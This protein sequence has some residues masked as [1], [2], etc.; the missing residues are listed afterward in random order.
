MGATIRVT[1]R[2]AGLE[3]SAWHARMI[4][5]LRA[6][7]GVEVAET[8]EPRPLLP[9]DVFLD[10][11]D[12]ALIPGGEPHPRFG[13]WRFVYGPEA[14]LVQPCA[15]EHAAGERGALA[16]LV[17][18]SAEGVASELQVG[19]IETVA[20]SLNSTRARMFDAVAEWPARALRRLLEESFASVCGSIV[21]ITRNAQPVESI[22][23]V[24]G[25]AR[26]IAQ[27]AIE[28]HWTIGL[29]RKPVSHVLQSF[30]ANAI[31][32]LAPPE[33]A[34]LADPLGAF[35]RDGRLTILAE[36]YDFT[37][38]QGRIV[39]IDV[40]VAPGHEPSSAASGG[41]E[42]VASARVA[43]R[44]PVVVTPR[45][46]LRLP[47]DASYPH[48]ISHG[49]HIYCLPEASASGRV[50]LYRADPFPDRWTPDRVLLQG[51]AGVD[52][53]LHRHAG[54]WWMFVGNLADQDETR[55]SVFHAS[56]LFGPWEPH[57]LNP[58]K[59]DLR[60][61]RSAGPL[62]EHEGAL[63]RPAQDG[64]VA[65]GGAVAVNRITALSPTQFSEET[66]AVLRP[67]ADGPYPHGLHTLTGVGSYTLVDGKRHVPSIK[68]L[69]WG[70]RQVVRRR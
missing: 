10:P 52:A 47:V 26:R 7:P 50:Q 44:E 30:D 41:K 16:R 17:C 31:E 40:P 36:G 66:V 23:A 38:R 27:E 6:L 59:C 46:V 57:T 1:V 45:E 35:E 24:R 5:R 29:I 11:T 8:H 54:R 33:G 14:R 25:L 63:Y 55:L 49:T 43:A 9:T 64:S 32:W 68:R 22:S 69:I 19:A 70:L 34:A 20:H 12:S 53:T 42:A 48:L 21:S 13:H 39:T 58:V 61:A 60:S 51:F 3:K 18:F 65:C 67:S 15:R 37:D 56:D 28:E 4:K 2:A 62:F